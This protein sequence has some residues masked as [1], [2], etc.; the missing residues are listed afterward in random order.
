MRLAELS[1]RSRV[2]AP[3]IKYYLR[4][5]LL[6]PGHAESST[7]AS[8]D[9]S[10]VRRLALVRALTEVGGLSLADVRRVLAV[11]DD[12]DASLHETLGTAQWL[13]S[14]APEVP[15]SEAALARV[16]ALLDRHG[17]QLHEA[18]PHRPTLAAALDTLESLD[19]PASD[20]VLDR[21]AGAMAGLA[22]EEL[23]GIPDDQDRTRAVERAV[24]GTL[25]FEPLLTTL[26]RIAHEAASGSRAAGDR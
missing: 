11:V 10:H 2:P 12:A 16:D 21:Y 24:V 3:T 6:H 19:V 17:W 8:Y 1:R 26:R 23:A 5:G 15:P 4:E 9:T 14:P 18:S 20:E 13:L 25:L 22:D 7:W